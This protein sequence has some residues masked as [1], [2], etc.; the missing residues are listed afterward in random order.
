MSSLEILK[1]I[2]KPYRYTLNN[3]VTIVES[4]SGKFVV[5]KQNK[6]LFTLFNYLSNRGFNH[7]PELVQNYRNEENVFSFIEEDIIPKEQ[8]LTDLASLLASLHNKTVYYKNVSLD[9]YKEIYEAIT[10]NISYLGTYFESLFLIF[11]KRNL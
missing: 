2:Y 3:N 4:S 11:A 5:K 10:N 9:D 1:S 8:K 7:Y 6:D